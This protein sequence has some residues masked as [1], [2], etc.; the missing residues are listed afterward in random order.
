M[1]SIKTALLAALTIATATP[2]MAVYK[3]KDATGRIAFQERPCETSGA[4]GKQIDIRPTA[5]VAPAAAPSAAAPPQTEVMRLRAQSEHSKK[6][7]RLRELTE[8]ELPAAQGRAR[9]A[10]TRCKN[11]MHAVGRQKVYANNNLAGAT[12]E[13]SLSTEMHAIATQCSS[14]ISLLNSEVDR[15]MMEKRMLEQELQR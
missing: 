8:R 13:Q 14:E 12:W 7:H 15:L 5:N 3:C 11:E 1:H 4:T 2:A 10:S 9:K 6:E